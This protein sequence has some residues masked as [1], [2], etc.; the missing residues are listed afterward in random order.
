MCTMPR[1]I[2]MV[3][4][5]SAIL[6]ATCANAVPISY[7]FSVTATYGPLAGVSSSG[8]FTFDSSSIT[9]GGRNTGEGLF[10]DL[11]FTWY[12]ITYTEFN[13]NTGHLEFDALGELIDVQFGTFCGY[14]SCSVSSLKEDWL[15]V[16]SPEA[17][18]FA[19]SIPPADIFTETAALR[20]VTATP[21][22]EPAPL[23][24]V[25]VA[26]LVA[27]AVR[28]NMSSRGVRSARGVAHGDHS[29]GK[30]NGSAQA[31]RGGVAAGV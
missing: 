6:F 21:V 16:G 8:T 29:S 24:L 14:V 9:P 23:A 18:A 31:C 3:V 27:G 12:G 30:W 13:A 11:S 20:R 5:A 22:S 4:G 15:F 25:A 19:Y 17:A 26:L 7:E 10:T 2:W 1:I 28:R